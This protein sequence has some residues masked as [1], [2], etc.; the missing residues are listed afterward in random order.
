MGGS[1]STTTSQNSA[2]NWNSNSLSDFMSQMSQQFNQ[3]N[4]QTGTSTSTTGPTAEAQK[5]LAQASQPISASQIANYQNPYQQQVIDA[6]MAQLNQQYGQ[7]QN[8]L[9][10][11]AISQGALGGD[12]A[13]VAMASLMGK[14]GMNTASALS[15]L[16]SAGYSQALQA[17]QADALRQLQAAGL[18]GTTTSG[19]TQQN[20]TSSGTSLG[21]TVGNSA[22]T[23][24]G[25]SNTF[26]S[27][28]SNTSNNPGIMGILGMLA[29]GG[30]VHYDDGG[31]VMG[32]PEWARQPQQLAQP[33]QQPAQQQKGGGGLGKLLGLMLLASGG[34]A[35]EQSHL[36]RLG[37]QS[38]SGLG[39]MMRAHFDDG[40]EVVPDWQ[41]Q[42]PL[43]VDFAPARTF[44]EAGTPTGPGSIAQYATWPFNGPSE[45]AG[46]Q[47]GAPHYD[48]TLGMQP[49][50]NLPINNMVFADRQPPAVDH[51]TIHGFSSPSPVPE[52]MTPTPVTAFRVKPTPSQE[53]IGAMQ[54]TPAEPGAEQ[55]APDAA[56]IGAMKAAP[57]NTANT[58]V[59]D[60]RS[61]GMSDNAIRGVLANVQHESG[62]VANLR[63]PDQPR[64]TGEA[65][66]A[67]GL[68]Q[69]GGEEWNKYDAWL[70]KNH[71][72]EGWENPTL[73]TQFMAENLQQN[74]PK[75][76]KTMNTGTPEEAAKA[77]L[78]GY[79]K[80]AEKYRTAREAQYSRGVG[81]LDELTANVPTS[82]ASSPAVQAGQG[83]M[84]SPSTPSA[85][86]TSLG[87]GA[88][89]SPSTPSAGKLIFDPRGGGLGALLRGEAPPAPA[90]GEQRGGILQRL[91]G[92]NFNP[93]GLSDNERAALIA[94]GFGGANGAQ[95]GMQALSGLRG[96]D[97][98]AQQHGQELAMRA[99]Q[100]AHSQAE[101]KV[102]GTA[103]DQYGMPQHQ[104]GAYN[105]QTQKYE[106][107]AT[108]GASTTAGA[109]GPGAVAPGDTTLKGTEYL[110][111]IP[112]EYLREH[113]TAILS[114]RE[115]LP[116]VTKN[117]PT[118]AMVRA[119]V[120]HADP[121]YDQGAYKYMQ[122]WRDPNKSVGM[123]VKATD[124]FYQ[125][126]GDLFDL[127]TA[128]PN[129]STWAQNA[130]SNWWSNTTNN[131]ELAAYKDKAFQVAEE[132]IKAIKGASP[133]QHEVD[134]AMKHYD[135][136]LGA[137]VV[138]RNLQEDAKSIDSRV[139]SL[140]HEYRRNVGRLAPTPEIL[141]EDSVA[142][143]GKILGKQG[144]A[145]AAAAEQAPATTPVAPQEAMDYLLKNPST[146]S[147][148]DAKYGRGAAAKVLGTK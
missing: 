37:S 72:N 36:Q 49:G 117:D 97:I 18:S 109:N 11:N 33:A 13:K 10:G 39:A 140:E 66:Y 102:M 43:N 81:S 19:T 22:T 35:S 89:Q 46:P 58:L 137:A 32:V 138:K 53:G 9:K 31:A 40:G 94:G 3:Q 98:Q 48:E 129:H 125:H 45:I 93:L 88:M 87:L 44:G 128:L 139:N 95:I 99:Q 62:F 63:H 64:F 5:L 21:T 136:S 118:A 111:S 70:K 124:T 29:N 61:S 90:A 69:I 30:R 104:Y 101:P 108:A 56:G 92:V 51:P 82:D 15:G 148:F 17:A 131:P 115:E 146:A 84:Q 74:Y 96:Q 79:L 122:N 14:Q 105:P 121:S 126:A 83:A 47:H 78:N 135:P 71:P 23:G 25:A 65:H 38:R 120:L 34:E 106:P 1:S 59:T 147:Y 107:L 54:P 127:T 42:Q 24:S 76:W 57:A 103:I 50:E 145:P 77:Y 119:A 73:Q 112:N 60:L 6:T 85:P 52:D 144:G 143:R 55:I 41:A 4:Q 2:T 113:T 110:N 100:L 91:L 80:P 130:A 142:A 12:R 67:H 86:S 8:Q 68:F 27:G 123:G 132:K 28:T 20:G 16:Q 26:G 116:K 134:E 133:T 114:G 7:Q 141:G 75:V